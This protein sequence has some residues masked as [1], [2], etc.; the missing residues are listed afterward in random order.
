VTLKGF[1]IEDIGNRRNLRLN[2]CEM[3]QIRIQRAEL[4]TSTES[5]ILNR[6]CVSVWKKE[7]IEQSYLQSCLPRP[8]PFTSHDPSRPIIKD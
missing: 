4:E 5:I 7:Q 3:E 2:G 8:Y 1:R 6:S